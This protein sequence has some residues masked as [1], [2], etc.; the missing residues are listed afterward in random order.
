MEL[1]CLSF[2]SVRKFG[3]RW[4]AR[5]LA[6]NVLINNAG[7]FAMNVPK[8]YSNDG[9]ETHMQVNHLAP[10]LL[11]VLLLPSLL[12]GAP[13]R[14]VMVNSIM[15]HLGDLDPTDLNKKKRADENTAACLLTQT[16]NLPRSC[17]PTCSK[18][19]CQGQLILMSSV[20]T[21]GRSKRMWRE[22]CPR[23][24]SLVSKRAHFS[25]TTPKK[26]QGLC[27]SVRR[28]QKS[29]IKPELCELTSILQS[30][31]LGQISSIGQ[32]PNRCKILIPLISCGKKHSD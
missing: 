31:T 20:C 2:D 24:C 19:S 11:T 26:V 15:H 6:L 23:L 1:D 7:I 32:L 9:C 18:D 30:C 12:R 13:S 16:A 3:E 4:E 28:I 8:K 27:F 22:P 14:V 5:K 25:V 17:S 10:A 29:R 21:L